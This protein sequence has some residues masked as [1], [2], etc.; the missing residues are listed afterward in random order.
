L[1]QPAG[2]AGAGRLGPWALGS[3]ACECEECRGIGETGRWHA[4]TIELSP[5]PAVAP[6][7]GVGLP[8]AP[9]PLRTVTA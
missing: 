9:T 8:P 7:Q 2:V 6:R 1:G 4:S 3:E 5:A